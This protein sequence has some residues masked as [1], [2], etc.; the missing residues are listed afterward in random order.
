[1]N[2]LELQSVYLRRG[3]FILHDI[4]FTIKQGE[5]VAVAGGSGCG[6]TTLV[7]VIGNAL[8]PDAGKVRYFGKELCEDEAG[9]RKRLSV[10]YDVPNFNQEMKA[11]RLVC[12]II[13]F[14]PWFD[15]EFFL[16]GMEELQLDVSA[17]IKQYSRRKKKKFMLL[18]ALCRKPSLLVM[19]D[20]F[21]GLAE[22]DRGSMWTLLQTYKETNDLTILFTAHEGDPS[23]ERADRVEHLQEG[24]LL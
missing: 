23:L 15:R 8:C 2:V 4:H 20:P 18:L 6:K 12:E 1:V 9:I 10:V 17:R 16:R 14:E 5:N 21:G 3:N 7:Y 22:E 24:G 19:D 11:E 13:R